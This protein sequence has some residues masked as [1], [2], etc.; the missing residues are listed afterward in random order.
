MPQA[1]L[2]RTFF[3]AG[4]FFKRPPRRTA[5]LI[6][7]L[8]PPMSSTC[9]I[10]FSLFCKSFSA[11]DKSCQKYRLNI[12]AV[13]RDGRVEPM[14]GPAHRFSRDERI[15]LLGSDGDVQKFLRF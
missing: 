1:L 2:S 10:F 9:F 11:D 4:R 15:I 6:Y 3:P 14:P 13:R 5:S 8:L 12:L 7:H